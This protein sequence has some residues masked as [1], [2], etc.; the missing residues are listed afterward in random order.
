M[1]AVDNVSL[2]VRAGEVHALMGENGAG[3]S[4]LMKT[5]SGSFDDYTGVI[6]I[7]GKAVELH[8]PAM[9]IANG[10]GMVYQELSLARPVSIAEN[11]FAGQLPVNKFGLID[12]KAMLKNARRALAYVS[13]D[14]DPLKT[15]EEISQH[16]AQLV[17]IA[18]VLAKKPCIL[19]LD[20]PTS[21]LSREEVRRLF[22]IVRDLRNRGLAIVYISH[23]LP[24][25][26]EIADRVTVL[27]DGRRVGTH[28][29]HEITPGSLVK[30]MVGQS[31]NE[32]YEHREANLGKVAL[33][34]NHLTRHGFFHDVSFQLREG[35]ILGVVGL[36]GAGR[37]E[38]ARSLC[39]LDPIHD[40]EVS[41]FDE[42]LSPDNYPDAVSKGL[43][44]LSE[45]R[46]VDGL[47]LRLPVSRNLV[48]AVLPDHSRAGIYSSRNDASLTQRYL[49][50]LGIVAASSETDVG[51]LSGGNQQ[52]VLLGKCLATQPRVLI[53]DE[54]SRGVD[55]KAKQRIHETVIAL[56]DRGAAILLISSDLPE[57]VG[58]SDRTVIMRNG[59]LTGEMAKE[60]LSEESALLAANGQGTIH[61]G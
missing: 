53:L 16:E 47:F 6:R 8:S 48:A 43:V 37:S 58:L 34:V 1:L 39:G 56:A 20:E 40:G 24:E 11:L 22:E 3:K 42:E 4:T 59:R 12:R 14:I 19:I 17:E 32:F 27:R 15:I 5:L 25:V 52:K 28:N 30:M 44:Y 23:H 13:L 35:E 18:K 61:N 33:S 26:F 49:D 51:T 9:A 45:D 2:E 7:G 55:V 46:K 41:L 10:I 60:E 54:P 31:I 57:L 36:C 29:I 21:S 50:E 38:M